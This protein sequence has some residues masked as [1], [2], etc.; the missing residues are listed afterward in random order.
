MKIGRSLKAK[1]RNPFDRPSGTIPGWVAALILVL[2]LAGA[3]IG[4]AV[5]R[6]YLND[7]LRGDMEACIECARLEDGT[8]SGTCARI[9]A[10]SRIGR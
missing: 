1:P 5:R 8:G 3:V 2:I 10:A 9:V 7:C 6:A 4:T